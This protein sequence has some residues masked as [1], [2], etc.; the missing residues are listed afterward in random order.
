ML[1]AIQPLNPVAFE[2]G[3]FAVRWYGILIGL[4]IVMLIYWP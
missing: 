1:L 3:P 2:L 4:G